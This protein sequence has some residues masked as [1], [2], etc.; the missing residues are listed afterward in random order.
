VAL[1]DGD[2]RVALPGELQPNGVNRLAAVLPAGDYVLELDA[3]EYRS[4]RQQV[5]VRVGATT[6]VRL[7]PR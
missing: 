1:V 7:R 4:V 6:T 5:V 2:L 3:G